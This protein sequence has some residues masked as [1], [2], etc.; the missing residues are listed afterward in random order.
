MY[1]EKGVLIPIKDRVFPVTMSDPL[2]DEETAA[3]KSALDDKEGKTE[4]AAEARARRARK[5]RLG[6]QI[7]HATARSGMHL[8]PIMHKPI[9]DQP[10][11]T[12]IKICPTCRVHHP[13]KTLHLYLDD[14]GSALVSDGVLDLLRS[15]GMDGFTQV[16][17]TDKPPPLKLG[18]GQGRTEMDYE[19]RSQVIYSAQQLQ[20]GLN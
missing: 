5:P 12:P 9:P 15:V 11:G 3:V 10:D 4:D 16:G 8:T 20:K 14:T 1:D 17:N 18:S 13:V 6:H 7:R 19:N 2:T